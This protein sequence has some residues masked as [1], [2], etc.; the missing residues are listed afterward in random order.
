MALMPDMD[1][2]A[3]ETR[4]QFLSHMDLVEYVDR[5]ADATARLDAIIVPAARPARNLTAA[6]DLA[7]AADCRLVVLCSKRTRPRHVRSLFAARRFA[8][9]TVVDVP[10]GYVLPAPRLETTDWVQRGPGRI[11]CGGRESDISAKRNLGLLLARML[12]WQRIFF[13]DDDIR[14]ISP[15][16]LA[17]TVALLSKRYRSAGIQ[18]NNYPDNSVVCHARREAKE[19][20]DVFLSASALAVDCTAPVAFFPDIYNEDWFFFYQDVAARR[21]AMPSTPTVHMEQVSHNP[22][23]DPQ[24]AAREEFGDVIAEG[25][26]SLLHKGMGLEFATSEYWLRFIADR[27]RILDGIIADAEL[28]PSR[29]QDQVTAAILTA[30]NTLEKIQPDL[31]VEYLDAWQLDL[32][33]WEERLASLPAVSSVSGALRALG[34]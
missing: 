14:E 3:S 5:P 33:R 17:A 18:V 26:Y 12:G 34:L 24:R 11:V 31:C 27:A 19:D 6:V 4:L 20:Q 1:D 15:R 29:I 25:I 8:R 23:A 9:G 28:A 16:D 30:R 32:I 7:K 21:I 13:L 22:F 10:E 2:P